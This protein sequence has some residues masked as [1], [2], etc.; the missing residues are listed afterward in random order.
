MF[1]IKKDCV[2]HVNQEEIVGGQS[3][4]PLMFLIFVWNAQRHLTP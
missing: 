4:E 2:E 3:I 1:T